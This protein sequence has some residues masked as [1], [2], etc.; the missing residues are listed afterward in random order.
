MGTIINQNEENVTSIGGDFLEN[1]AREAA[2]KMLA[3]ALEAEV[4]E[5]ISSHRHLKMRRDTRRL[6]GTVI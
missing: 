1:L 3:A 4:E 5:F 2:R 6:S